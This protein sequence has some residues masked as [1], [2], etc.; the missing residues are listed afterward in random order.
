M[1]TKEAVDALRAE[2]LADADYRLAWQS[3]IAMAFVDSFADAK[4]NG[5]DL[6]AVANDA[7][8]RFLT[9]LCRPD[10]EPIQSQQ[11]EQKATLPDVYDPES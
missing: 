3:N 9:T 5:F 10:P 11:E 6:H 4:T 2:L 7:A 8:D 1:T